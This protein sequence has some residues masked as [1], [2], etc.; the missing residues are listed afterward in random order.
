MLLF[1]LL[2]HDRLVKLWFDNNQGENIS[3]GIETLRSR[4]G[5]LLQTR[6]C[7]LRL[8]VSRYPSANIWD[9]RLAG[10][11]SRLPYLFSFIH[12]LLF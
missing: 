12:L 6:N 8:T 3:D 4:F 7:G 11:G 1:V 5:H 2:Q 10:G 9:I